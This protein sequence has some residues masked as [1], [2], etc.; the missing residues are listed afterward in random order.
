[1]SAHNERV[2]VESEH[3]TNSIVEPMANASVALNS[4]A[5]EGLSA[6]CENFVATAGAASQ[7]WSDT[8]RAVVSWSEGVTN[9]A[10]NFI[11]S[12]AA[13]HEA[14]GSQVLASSAIANAKE[15]HMTASVKFCLQRMPTKIS[16][17]LHYLR[18]VRHSRPS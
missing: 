15:N 13:A 8:N 16:W 6:L 10:N 1:M 9:A 3:V 12:S 18:I 7:T 2:A 11:D 4:R 17:Y 14:S 5:S